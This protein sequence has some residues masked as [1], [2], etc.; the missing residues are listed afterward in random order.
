M[1]TPFRAQACE[2]GIQSTTEIAPTDPL[3]IMLLAIQAL[4]VGSDRLALV[5]HR[6]SGETP[7][8]R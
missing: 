3:V 6:D 2:T 4:T 7:R 1:S 5:A 8:L